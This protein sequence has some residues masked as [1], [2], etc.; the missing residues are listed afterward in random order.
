MTRF[1]E[2]KQSPE[3]MALAVAFCIAAYLSEYEGHCFTD[4]SLKDFMS[5]ISEGVEEWL[6]TE[7]EEVE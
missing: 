5:K 7:V 4:D 2:A 6:V 1:E 3:D